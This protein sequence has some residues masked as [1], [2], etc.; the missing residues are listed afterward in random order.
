ML[1]VTTV[2][3]LRLNSVDRLIPV[4]QCSRT[5]RDVPMK[6]NFKRL[7]MTAMLLSSTSI[8][9]ADES[10]N[11]SVGDLPGFGEDAYFDGVGVSAQTDD[12][13]VDQEITEQEPVGDDQE[14]AVMQVSGV[15]TTTAQHTWRSG[16][17]YPTTLQPAAYQDGGILGGYIDHGGYAPACGC[18]GSCD[19]GCGGGC[20]SSCDGN[21]DDGCDSCCDGYYTRRYHCDFDIRKKL[22]DCNTWATYEAL[23]WFPQPRET[24]VLVASADPGELPILDPG[25]ALNSNVTSLFGPEIDGGMSAGVRADYGKW[26][27]EN[28]GIGG[29]FWW[30]DNNGVSRSGTDLNGANASV[31]I[32]FFEISPSA[33]N[34]VGESA[35]LIAYADAD[36]DITGSYSVESELQMMAAEF[37]ARFRLGSSSHHQIDLIGGYSHFRIDDSL[38]LAAENLILDSPPLAPPPGTFRA[39]RDHEE[40]KNRF[41][42]GQ[43]GFELSATRGSW[44]V[45]SLT[46][47]HLGNMQQTYIGSGR[48]LSG[49]VGNPPPTEFDDGMFIQSSNDGVAERDVFTFVPEANFKVG[50]RFRK[51]VLLS[52]GYSFIYFDNVALSGDVIDR[53][54]NGPLLFTG[55]SDSRPAFNFDDSSLWVQGVDLGIV[56]D[57]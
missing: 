54:I 50:Y 8:S 43:V 52:V 41:N 42:G 1:G 36:T 56:I 33:P 44:M 21:C 11:A 32:P 14:S 7:A 23:L 49:L 25:G 6:I 12:W 47:V 51:N 27:D 24:P 10:S 45:R 53:A 15:D 19:G 28:V 55:V 3:H 20:V 30:I 48:S 40:A 5:V 46:K 57:F 13:S 35:L 34:G 17:E 18:E 37:Y 38:R 29:R 31:G 16:N 2:L 26:I 22:I 4:N 39:F 9:L